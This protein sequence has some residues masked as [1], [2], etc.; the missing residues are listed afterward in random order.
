MNKKKEQKE[1]EGRREKCELPVLML[2]PDC[3]IKETSRR[4]K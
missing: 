1:Y 2:P 3:A 4:N